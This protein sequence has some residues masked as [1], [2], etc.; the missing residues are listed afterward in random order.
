MGSAKYPQMSTEYWGSQRQTAPSCSC[1]PPGWMKT[2]GEK[3]LQQEQAPY[4]C[5]CRY[6]LAH[7]SVANKSVVSQV[8][9]GLERSLPPVSVAGRALYAILST[10]RHQ[11]TTFRIL[12]EPLPH[13]V[14]ELEVSDDLIQVRRAAH[15]RIARYDVYRETY[16]NMAS[17]GKM[18][19]PLRV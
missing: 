18:S 15:M 5:C 19:T 3:C 8:E 14:R 11:G 6:C 17:C 9:C 1:S 16:E 4:F 12:T 13:L 2:S 7:M 10:Y